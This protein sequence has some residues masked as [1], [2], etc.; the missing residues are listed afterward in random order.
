MSEQSTIILSPEQ[1]DSEGRKSYYFWQ[2]DVGFGSIAERFNEFAN[3]ECVTITP[4]H[5]PRSKGSNDSRN[6]NIASDDDARER[7]QFFAGILAQHGLL[8]KV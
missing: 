5:Q 2:E 7:V 8:R 3:V 4:F 6:P 1:V